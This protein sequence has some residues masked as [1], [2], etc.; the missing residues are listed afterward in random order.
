MAV[1]PPEMMAGQYRL[2]FSYSAGHQAGAN[3]NGRGEND[4][5]ENAQK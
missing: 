3:Q 5:K 2:A 1:P 4:G